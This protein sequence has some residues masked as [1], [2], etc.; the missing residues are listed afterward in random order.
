MRRFITR[1]AAG[2]LTIA[3]TLGTAVAPCVAAADDAQA[4]APTRA[5][6]N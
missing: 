4:I 1:A 6:R 2:A 5:R 3:L